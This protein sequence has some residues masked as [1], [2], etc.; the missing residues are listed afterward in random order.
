[1]SRS[2]AGVAVLA[3][4]L[5]ASRGG[6]GAVDESKEPP[7]QFKLTIGDNSV[8]LVEGEPV[9]IDGTFTNPQVKLTPEPYRLFPYAGVAFEYPRSFTFEADFENPRHR[10]WT[11]SGNDFKIMY[12][13][14]KA[15]L[16]PGNYA[17]ELI[18]GLGEAQCK[19][20]D[21]DAKVTLGK[22]TLSGTK[23]LMTVAN[24]PVSFEIYALPAPAGAKGAR[25]L[26]FQDNVD[27]AGGGHTKEGVAT[28][29]VLKRTFAIKP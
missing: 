13:D 16:T 2:F 4:L 10:S 21:P 12:F 25:L 22:H 23:L 9:R 28:L 6:L 24:Q 3:C 27:E 18:A 1:M 29:E 11:L 26:V 17:D 19:V 20:M 8:P 14:V 5:C 15:P 7:Q